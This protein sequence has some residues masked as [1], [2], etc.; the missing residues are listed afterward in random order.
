MR[1]CNVLVPNAM[2]KAAFHDV[3]G[4]LL[5]CETRHMAL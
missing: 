3:K 5:H 2:Q 1:L 4:R